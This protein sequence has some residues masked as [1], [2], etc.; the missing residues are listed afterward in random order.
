MHAERRCWRCS[1]ACTKRALSL[2]V[3]A[4]FS[5]LCSPQDCEHF[6]EYYCLE[7]P[8][9]ET[10]FIL[11]RH[12][13]F[14]SEGSSCSWVVGEQGL[15]LS[16]NTCCLQCA[17]DCC[18]GSANAGGILVAALPTPQTLI[19]TYWD[20]VLASSYAAV[21][22]AFRGTAGARLLLTLVIDATFLL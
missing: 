16:L 20:C 19:A 10:V 6:A 8:D 14:D 18:A 3:C 11:K 2:P 4:C 5:L 13:W 1:A 7:P 17:S 15:V 12:A 9:F 21:R 22:S